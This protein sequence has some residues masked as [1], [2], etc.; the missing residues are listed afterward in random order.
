MSKKYLPKSG[1]N[2]AT[3]SEA[4]THLDPDSEMASNQA[5]IALL[6]GGA[7]NQD[8]EAALTEL[9]ISAVIS[10]APQ[11]HEPAQQIADPPASPP[12]AEP[13]PDV[14]VPALAPDVAVPAPAPDVAVPASAPDVA[15]LAPAPDVAVP[16]PAPDVAVPAP[17]PDVAVP[18]PDAAEPA[19][20]ITAPPAHRLTAMEG[21]NFGKRAYR[22]DAELANV[23][24]LMEGYNSAEEGSKQRRDAEAALMNA[25]MA[26]IQ[27]NSTGE[28]ARHKGRTAQMEDIIYQLS[29]KGGVRENAMAQTDRLTQ[30]MEFEQLPQP[31]FNEDAKPAQIQNAQSTYELN[32]GLINNAG[33]MRTIKDIAGGQNERYSKAL[34]A[35]TAN[36]MADQDETDSLISERA[37]GTTRTMALNPADHSETRRFNVT[38]NST[39][40]GSSALG[41]FLHEFTHVSSGKTFNN[42]GMYLTYDPALGEAG[43]IDEYRQRYQTA[44]SLRQTVMQSKDAALKYFAPSKLNYATGAIALDYE[45]AARGSLQKDAESQNPPASPRAQRIQRETGLLDTFMHALNPAN[46]AER[47]LRRR[48]SATLVEYDSVINQM[49]AQYET[50]YS[51]RDS[52]YYRQLKAAALAS[53]VKRHNMRL[54]NQG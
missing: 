29:M 28:K 53:H 6:T 46:E 13:A 45:Q 23:G 32:Q 49:L 52:K 41:T 44:E 12:I 16:S 25:A 43:I 15:V 51:E 30:I 3:Q 36:V 7:D 20:Q 9:R 47:I 5:V 17:A 10:G 39:K 42:T 2:P 50:D 37:S 8:N 38:A 40:P 19:P 35:I 24:A 22:N 21:F 33:P 26:Y 4:Q 18:V 14:A 1:K 34:S 11:N 27:Q 48:S 31:V 54:K